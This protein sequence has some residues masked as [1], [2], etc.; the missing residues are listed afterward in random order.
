MTQGPTARASRDGRLTQSFSANGAARRVSHGEVIYRSDIT[1]LEARLRALNDELAQRTSER[2]EVARLL[3]DAR[4]C[5]SAL[6]WLDERPARQRRRCRLALA[7]F[8]TVTLAAV[9]S[10]TH[11]SHPP[12]QTFEKTLQQSAVLADQACGC[13]DEECARRVS[14][15]LHEQSVEIVERGAYRVK[16]TAQQMALAK[17]LGDRMIACLNYWHD[18]HLYRK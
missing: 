9:G 11:R 17:Q 5:D 7:A 14:D 10:L 8:L 6:R 2:D 3:R 12:Q 18:R 15:E 16:P 1:A 13:T 4:A